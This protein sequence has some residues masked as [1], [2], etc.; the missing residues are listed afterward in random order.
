[1]LSWAGEGD[2]ALFE[3]TAA[4]RGRARGRGRTRPTLAADRVPSR[5]AG[6]RRRR[7]GARRPRRSPPSGSAGRRCTASARSLLPEL[8]ALHADLRAEGIDRVV[9]AGHGRLLA[10]ARRSSPAPPGVP[11]VVLDSTDPGQVRAALERRPRPHRGRGVEQVRLD[12]RDRLASAACSRPAFT[13]AGLDAT[14]HIVVV[15]DPGS[16]LEQASREAG[17]RAVFLADPEVGGRFSAL[18]AFGLVP[19]ALAG[20]DVGEL[21]DEAASVARSCSPRTPSPTPRSSSAPRS[22][23]P[24]RCATSWSSSTRAPASSASATGPSSSS[25]SRPAS[26]APAC[27]PSSRRAQRSEASRPSWPPRRRRPRDPP[28]RHGRRARR[29]GRRRGRPQVAAPGDEVTVAGPLGAQFLLW[30][31]ATAIAGRLLGIN[32]F[33]QPD[34]ESAKIAARGLLDATP[35][36]RAGRVHRRRH[37]GPRRPPACWTAST[38]VEGALAALLGAAR[39]PRLPRRDGVPRPGGARRPRRGPGRA[40]RA[41]R[42]AGHLRLGAALPALDRAA[43]QGRRPDRR[44]PAGHR[45][46]RPRT[47][48]SPSRPFTFGRL[49]AAQA[50]GDAHG[51]GRPR[52]PG[53]APAP[54]RTTPPCRLACRALLGAREGTRMS[55]AQV[56]ADHNPLRD[57][58][59]RRLPRIAGPCGLVIFG[60]TGDLARKKLMPAVYDLT[61][62]GL[63]PPGFALTGFARRDWDDPGLRRGRAR[64]GEGVRAHAVPRGDLEPARRGHPVRAGR[65]RRRRRVRPARATPSRSWTPSAARA[66]TTRSTS[67]S[68]RARSR[69]SA[70]SSRGPGCRSPSRDAWRRV[71]IEKPFGHDLASARELNDVV[72]E[73]FPPDDVFRIDHYLGQGDGP[74]PAGAAVR[75]PALRAHLERQLR[76]PRADHDGRGHR[77][78]RPRGVLRRHRRGPRR[79]PEPPAPAARAHGD[80]GAGLVRRAGPAR[81]EDEGAVGRP[82]AQATSASTPPRG[83]YARRAGRAARRSSGTSRRRAS[84]RTRP[85][86]RTPRSG[87]TST[88]A[89]GPGVPFYLRTG[90]R[91]G[92]RVTEIAVVFK[93]APH[94]PFESTATEEL[95]KNALVIRVQPDEGVTLRFGAKVPGTAMEVRDVTM[96]FGYGH[97][98]TESSP[99]GLR[100]AHPRRPAR[101]PAAVP[102]ARGGRAVLEDPRPDRRSTGRRNGARTRTAPAPG[103]RR[104]PTR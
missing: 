80:G 71:V 22:A 50:A 39:R 60:V 44:L 78:R 37:R 29:R 93:R 59:D 3:V 17:Y 91:L 99:G 61:N 6:A 25:P 74:E 1:M 35:E 53:A 2:G 15:T 66:A 97:A 94:L 26:P 10:G 14:R 40:R 11:L 58:R 72:S 79:H 82:A 41:H 31:Y 46:A 73:V 36:P 65:V 52:T 42:A 95:G 21:L 89:A 96:D 8:E 76:R 81:R 5:I 9:L 75:Q 56:T 19:S 104:R 51:P 98:F 28:G 92:R 90:K 103:A 68:R 18:T 47:S 86:R 49:I 63:L 69:S 23:A 20:V 55:P 24:T 85:P 101:R 7:C 100:A 27:C 30:E 45:R 38:D 48:R 64:L 77:H 54:D 12:G 33:D 62:R 87:S 43:P 83:Q 70:S 34:V 4:G 32:P 88:P 13:A 67:R 102:A 84:R 16:P 57:P